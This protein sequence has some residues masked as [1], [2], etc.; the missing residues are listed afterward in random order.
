MHELA[1]YGQIQKDDHHRMLQQLAGFTR[2]QPQDA[3]EIRLVFKARQ[4]PGLDLV[5][6]IGASNL[7]SQQQQDIQRLKNML[8]AGLYYIHLIG[9][10]QLDK[11]EKR[12]A[13]EDVTMTNGYTNNQPEKSTVSWTLEFKDTPEAGKQA[14]SSR[15]ISRTPMEGDLVRF[16]GS[17][18]FEYVPTPSSTAESN[19]NS[20]AGTYPAT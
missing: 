4:P 3:R 8:N 2:M 17:F 16:L 9:A 20:H 10:V 12:P 11:K 7:A 1:L 18:G 15:L 19:A 6:S 13:T 14:V 5:Q